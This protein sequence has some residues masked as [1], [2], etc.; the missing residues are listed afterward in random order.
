M[1]KLFMIFSYTDAQIHRWTDIRMDGHT[2]FLQIESPFYPIPVRVEIF[3]TYISICCQIETSV[4]NH[5]WEDTKIT[6]NAF[7]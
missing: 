1:Q 6:K 2:N 4:I 3:S 7:R 5:L